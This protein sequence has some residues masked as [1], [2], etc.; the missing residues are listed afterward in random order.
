MSSEPCS[1]R[2]NPFDDSDVAS[3]KRRRTSLAG[4]SRS[5]SLE[6]AASSCT[7]PSLAVGEPGYDPASDSAMRIDSGPAMPATPDRHSSPSP[8][9]PPS[10]PR[11]SRVTINV[12][13][14]SR[15]SAQGRRR[16]SSHS[17]SPVDRSSAAPAGPADEVK[18]SVEEAE[19][20]MS[21]ED[22]VVDTPASLVSNGSSSPAVVMVSGPSDDEDDDDPGPHGVT[23]IQGFPRISMLRDP[24]SPF[25]FREYPESY[26]ETMQR[27]TVFIHSCG[28]N[29]CLVERSSR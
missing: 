16:P 24:S 17:P 10:G 7:Q 8:D 18:I 1:T 25:P 12:R 6:S 26:I 4:P 14:P 22:T 15:P 11:S 5:R 29:S 13:T 3:R 23:I 9:E 2:P 20:D 27:L 19:I 21:R 28:F